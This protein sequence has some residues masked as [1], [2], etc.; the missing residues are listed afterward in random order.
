MIFVSKILTCDLELRLGAPKY[1]GSKFFL[2][3]HKYLRLSL[4]SRTISHE[5]T[6]SP[7]HITTV[8]PTN[9]AIG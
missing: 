1:K 4:V 5:F 8:Q 9:D 3:S 6:M 7:L 2:S